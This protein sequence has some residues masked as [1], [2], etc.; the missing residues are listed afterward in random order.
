MAGRRRFP[1]GTVLLTVGT[2]RGLFLLTSKDRRTWTPHGPFQAGHRVY[3][4]ALDLRGSARLFAAANGDFFASSLRYSDDFG[5]TWQEPERGIL[6]PEGSGRSLKNMWIVEPGRSSEPDTLYCGVDPA[7]LFVSHDRGKTW[8]MTEGLENHPTRSRWQPGA[9]GLCLHSVVLDPT[10]AQRMW[11]AISAVGVLR[12]DDG[13]AT[14]TFCNKGTRADFLPDKYPEYGQ[15]VHRLI[16]H[17]S[18]PDVLFQQNHCGT[19]VTR[20][21][22]DAWTDIQSNLP[23]DFGFPLAMDPHDPDTLYTV[24]ESGEARANITDQFTVYR[25]ENGGK[26][27]QRL[28]RG[29]PKGPAV[30]LGVLRHGLCADT[31]DPCGLYVGTNTGQIF[32]SRDRGDSWRL[33]AD[34]LPSIYSVTVTVL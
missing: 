10:N 14:W 7:A 34:F 11:V 8:A 23:S 3:H 30:R 18:K 1:T 9:G 25:T 4:A 24:V 27:W 12:T 31:R 15:C 29:L 21:A 20:N 16:G 13:G 19:Y 33:I 5:K 6:F 28:T 26:R 17:P 2:K 32:A 22:G